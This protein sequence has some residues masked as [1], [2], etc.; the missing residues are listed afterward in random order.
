MELSA[1]LTLDEI[2]KRGAEYFK[3]QTPTDSMYKVGPA[4]EF[5]KSEL[6]K[7]IANDAAITEK[8]KLE[9]DFDDAHTSILENAIS[10]GNKFNVGK[11]VHVYFLWQEHGSGNALLYTVVRDE[12]D[13]FDVENP[14]VRN[15]RFGN[16]G[17]NWA[18]SLMDLVYN[19]ND[20]AVYMV[21]L[22]T[23]KNAQPV[24]IMRE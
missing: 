6:S 8:E 5:L 10:H 3:M 15:A 17:L 2:I 9:E 4:L 22:I 16:E 7:K 20:S 23:R 14:V 12:G 11:Y 21:K 13:G 19:F 24:E 1:K 18:K